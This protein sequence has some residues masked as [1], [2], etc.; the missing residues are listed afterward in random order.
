MIKINNLKKQFTKQTNNKKEK[1][2]AVNDVSIEIKEGK[3][4]GILGPNGAGK[5]TLHRVI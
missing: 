3:I 2:F 1:F 4:I 5:T